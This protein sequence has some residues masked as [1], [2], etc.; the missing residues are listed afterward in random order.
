MLNSINKSIPI[1]AEIADR[2]F[3]FLFDSHGMGASVR[4][5]A[6]VK[7]TNEMLM[8]KQLLENANFSDDKYA[9]LHTQTC[10]HSTHHNDVIEKRN[11][12][13]I[14][15]GDRFWIVGHVSC[16]RERVKRE[17]CRLMQNDACN[18]NKQ[19]Y[20]TMSSHRLQNTYN[21]IVW[22]R[23]FALASYE[24]TQLQ[25][26]A[27]PFI[28]FISHSSCVWKEHSSFLSNREISFQKAK[29]CVATSFQMSRHVWYLN[30][31]C[32]SCLAAKSEK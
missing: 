6:G 25:L 18:C 31:V 26:F 13:M 3:G 12:E 28:Y 24:R 15:H 17:S 29:N 5:S 8:R 22:S 16:W 2:L 11:G 9:Q 20:Y 4:M 1:K 14:F 23:I 27:C 7:E 32:L 10:V 30:D 21:D 19:V